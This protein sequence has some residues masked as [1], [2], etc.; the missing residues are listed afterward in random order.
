MLDYLDEHRSDSPMA[1][2]FDMVD[3]GFVEE[4]KVALKEYDE[5]TKI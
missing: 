5:V 3:G 1:G 4:M 2:H